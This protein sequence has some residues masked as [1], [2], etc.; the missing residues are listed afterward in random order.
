MSIRQMK[1]REFLKV[2]A[3]ALVGAVATACGAA[4]TAAP[5]VI[6]ETQIVK[7]V[8]KETQVV[9]ETVK[10]TQVVQVTV[11]V[12]KGFTEPPML[13]ER[14]KAGKLPPITDRLPENPF[15]VGGREAIG[16]Y[17]GEI[18][19]SHFDPIWMVSNYDL[20]SERLLQYSDA[21]YRTIYAN[22]LE[23]YE[24]TPDGK[25]WTFYM[26][27]GLKWSD[28]TPMTTE[29]VRFWW[30][31]WQLNTEIQS[32]PG[33]QFRFG[34]EPM[35]VD[36]LNDFTYKF[37]FAVPFGNFAAHM[38]R[39]HSNSG[40]PIYPS[41]F[42]KKFHPKYADPAELEQAVKDANVEGWVNLF[43]NW[44]GWGVGSWQGPT[45]GSLS[46]KDYPQ[47]NA[48]IIVDNPSD[49]LYLWERNPYYF[50]V[51]LA[52][53]QLPY[54][55]TLRYDYVANLE[56]NKL[57]ITQAEL[58]IVGMHDVTIADYPFYKENEANSNYMVADMSSC[59][60]DRYV[61]FPQHYVADADGN[62]D[63]GWNDLIQ[64]H[65]EFMQALSIAIDRD[66]INESK[67]YG[68]ALAGQIC[69]HPTSKYYKPKYGSA[70]ATYDPAKAEELLDSIGCKKGP[71][72]KRV[73]PDGK[74]LKILIEH[75]GPRVGPSCAEISEM[76]TTYWNAIGIEATS[77]EIQESL[78]GERMNTH[79][80]YCGVWHADRCTDMLL[81][82]QPQWFIPTADA[83]QGTC[84]SAWTQWYQAADKTAEG[85]IEPPQWIKDLYEYFAQMTSVV[86][87]DER[88]MWG[89]KI[90]D[91]LAERPLEIGII[92]S[93]PAPLLFN[94]NMR[95]LPRPGAPI[96]WDTY[97]L[98]TYHPEAFYYEGGV[99]A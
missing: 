7:E 25:E 90:F 53:N 12:P 50:K 76:I 71:D 9:K 40:G 42:L 20:N 21:D 98:S 73:R 15:V 59:M 31:D 91:F 36:I 69:P 24:V 2:S 22:V 84:C 39:W 44:S 8:V 37:T 85:L 77:K 95:N 48:W 41:H 67:F 47:I 5:Q 82:I 83:A 30:E 55:D 61:F 4:P 18:R 46:A 6:K 66:E 65:P 79:Q 49:G 68:L 54:I 80:V 78:Y 60:S 72:G 33:W 1:R 19:M 88:V 45:F 63:E 57:K 34:G 14:V 99:R 11:E 35:K 13:E 16:V 75:A 10:E 70:W 23:S 87:E 58:D 26:R 81:H 94:K 56:A 28:G 29:D 62:P 86:S 89:Q 74:P 51:D 52:G 27:K 96:G 97:G 43:N 32:A 17:G 38:T 3:T 64:N 92:Q 93:C